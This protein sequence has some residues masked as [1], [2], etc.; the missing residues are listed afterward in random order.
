MYKLKIGLTGTIAA[1]M[2]LAGIQILQAGGRG[3]RPRPQSWVDCELF[4]GVVTPAT[5]D[6]ESD[7]FDELYGGGMDSSMEYLSFQSRSLG[8]RTTTAADGI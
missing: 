4:A 6:P 2:L 1:V 5:F 7:P 8:I 3:P